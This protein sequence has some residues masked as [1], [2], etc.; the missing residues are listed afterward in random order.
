MK[1]PQVKTKQLLEE[2]GRV[3]H[4]MVMNAPIAMAILRRRHVIELASTFYWK[5]LA[6]KNEEVVGRS[7]LDTI[8]GTATQKYPALLDRVFKRVLHTRKRIACPGGKR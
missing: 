5:D 8:S 4:G 2:R 3:F 7:I 1:L 6:Q